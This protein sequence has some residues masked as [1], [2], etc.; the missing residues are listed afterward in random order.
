M[1][2]L[3]VSYLSVAL[4][5]V[6]MWAVAGWLGFG[7]G[8]VIVALGAAAVI[9]ALVAAFDRSATDA[10]STAAALCVFYGVAIYTFTSHLTF[11]DEIVPVV[12]LVFAIGGAKA[13]GVKCRW[14]LVTLALTAAAACVTFH[15]ASPWLASCAL[16]AVYVGLYAANRRWPE[17][18]AVTATPS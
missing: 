3:L 18:F 14:S 10:A 16:V 1:N 5:V 11:F 17:Q 6:V 4:A 7:R 13:I 15:W 2:K 8:P 12:A 9:A